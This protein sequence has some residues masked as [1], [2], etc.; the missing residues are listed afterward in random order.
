MP[1][2]VSWREATFGYL[3]RRA[4]RYTSVRKRSILDIGPVLFSAIH[5]ILPSN[6]RFWQ[7]ATRTVHVCMSIPVLC[8][9]QTLKALIHKPAQLFSMRNCA[10]KETQLII[11]RHIFTGIRRVY[12]GRRLVGERRLLDVDVLFLLL[13]TIL[14]LLLSGWL[15]KT[16]R[17]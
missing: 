11:L 10:C 12:V 6:L 5:F 17:P 2:V 4:W 15:W 7:F 1:S 14:P 16:L 9:C 8:H 13:S 3:G